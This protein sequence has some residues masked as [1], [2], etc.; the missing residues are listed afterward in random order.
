MEHS[1]AEA[2]QNLDC[3]T[4]SCQASIFT[5]QDVQTGLGVKR[6]KIDQMIIITMD[7]SSTKL[8]CIKQ[9]K[10]IQ[11]NLIMPIDAELLEEIHTRFHSAY[12]GTCVS[13]QA[14]PHTEQLL[15]RL[16]YKLRSVHLAD[17][18]VDVGLPVTK[19]TTLNEVLELARPPT[20][21]RVRQL[22][23]PEEVRCLYLSVSR[24]KIVRT[25]SC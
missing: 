11:S 5:D 15:H 1:V 24:G 7:P 19:V 16:R 2:S 21:V 14:Y 8:S 3:V 17:E 4:V 25:W 6:V 20:T 12:I 23:G 13:C 22:E 9:Y 18:L 10:I